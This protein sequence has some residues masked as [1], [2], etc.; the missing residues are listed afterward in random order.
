MNFIK[1]GFR[2]GSITILGMVFLALFIIIVLS[3]YHISLQSWF[4]NPELKSNLSY[5]WHNMTYLWN[6]Y[7]SAPAYFIWHNIILD[8]LKSLFSQGH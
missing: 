6:N 8:G 4:N 1:F 7:L 5:V 2:K 3:H